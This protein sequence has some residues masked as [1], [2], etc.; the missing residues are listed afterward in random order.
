[1]TNQ[2]DDIFPYRL[3][4]LMMGRLHSCLSTFIVA[5]ALFFYHYAGLTLQSASFSFITLLTYYPTNFIADYVIPILLV[6]LSASL[7]DVDAVDSHC[8]RGWSSTHLTSHNPL[9]ILTYALVYKPLS[10]VARNRADWKHRGVMHTPIGLLIMLCVWGAIILFVVN[11]IGSAFRLYP[12][13]STGFAQELWIYFLCLP[14]SY[15]L[16]IVE[17]SLTVSGVHFLGKTVRGVLVTGKTDRLFVCVVVALSLA[18]DFYLA[19]INYSVTAAGVA[20]F[21]LLIFSM[22]TIWASAC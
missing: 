1:M 13:S 15:G 18:L 12:Q 11:Y 3:N 17:D 22:L 2:S 4:T 5:E 14:L 7:P 16:H 8:K 19:S 6:Y 20:F 9:F 21:L 10:V